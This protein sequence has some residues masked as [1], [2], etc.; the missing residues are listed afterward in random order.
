MPLLGCDNFRDIAN[1]SWCY[2]LFFRKF[3][4]QHLD[5]YDFYDWPKMVG[6]KVN[7]ENDTSSRFLF[8]PV[9]DE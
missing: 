9:P 8:S 7:R 4:R 6:P 1:L 3:I 5:R 2:A